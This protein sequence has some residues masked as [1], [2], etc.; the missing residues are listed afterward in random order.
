MWVLGAAFLNSIKPLEWI[1][2]SDDGCFST[3][4]L[5]SAKRTKSCGKPEGSTTVMVIWSSP[6]PPP[7]SVAEAV[8][9]CVPRLSVEVLKLAPEPIAPSMLEVQLS[10]ALMLPSSGSMAAPVK[11]METP[12]ENVEPSG[13]A[14]VA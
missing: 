1:L 9:V 8:I 12:G 10:E 7:E 14:A 2:P 13:G 3:L 6:V 11:L 4:T 5:T